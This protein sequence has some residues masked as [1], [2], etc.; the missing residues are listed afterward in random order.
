MNQK[1]SGQKMHQSVME[2]KTKFIQDLINIIL[3]FLNY[4]KIL[5]INLISKMK[6]YIDSK[7]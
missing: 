1:N 6:K 4:K 3:L 7:L 5:K 2:N